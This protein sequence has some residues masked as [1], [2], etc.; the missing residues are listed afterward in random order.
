MFF[1]FLK[2]LLGWLAM[3]FNWVVFALLVGII[4]L[5]QKRYPKLRKRAGLPCLFIA[6]AGFAVLGNVGVSNA[7]VA[8]LED[9]YPPVPETVPATEPAPETV[10]G[11]PTPALAPAP[12]PAPSSLSG[13]RYVFVAGA[14]AFHHPRRAALMR[15][16]SYSLA[17]LTEGI[18]ILNMLPAE[19]KLVVSGWD[20]GTG[21][22]EVRT[23]AREYEQAAI[24]LGVPASRIV[25]FDATRDTRQE[26][27]ALKKLAGGA[28][29]A[30]VTNAFHMRRLMGLC[31]ELGVDA[32]PC[33]TGYSTGEA[34]TGDFFKW[35]IGALGQ[36]G[37]WLH[38]ILGEIFA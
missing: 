4:L 3:P 16:S 23:M 29:V 35:G 30:V 20:G 2:K 17:R 32:A 12:A 8:L 7:L 11:K 10:L 1:F 27:E 13:C 26:I 14:G 21:V 33:P 28:R 34:R 9:A 5:R 36:S 37:V 6:F 15:L 18:R 22:A 19:T 25:R 24:S 38:E 31:K